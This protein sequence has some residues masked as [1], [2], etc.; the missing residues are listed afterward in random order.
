MSGQIPAPIGSIALGATLL[1]CGAGVVVPTNFARADDCLT[2]PNSPAPRGSH[3]YYQTDRATKRKCWFL[4][5]PGQ[6]TQPAAQARS[7]AAHTATATAAAPMSIGPEDSARLNEPAPQAGRPGVGGE[8]PTK[9]ARADKCLTTPN[10]PAPD[11]S[12]WYYKTDRATRRKCWYLRTL[13][14][15]T[16]PGAQATSEAASATH[17]NALKKSVTAAGVMSTSPGDHA[18]LL[19][20]QPAPMS[21]ATTNKLGQQSAHE[22][23]TGSS[24]PQAPPPQ[25]STSS[26]RSVEAAGLAPAPPAITM[27][28]VRRLVPSD[29]H[30]HSTQ[31][32][33]N[34]QADNTENT[35]RG[36]ASTNDTGT[37]TSLTANSGSTTKMV[38]II[39]L[40]LVASGLLYRAV[41]KIIAVRRRQIIV[42]HPESDWIDDQNKHKSQHRRSLNERDEL[43]DVSHPSR[44]DDRQHYFPDEPHE[45]AGDPHRSWRDN[46]Q[47]PRSPDKRDE[48]IDD[49]HRLRM[50][51]AR[52]YSAR[53]SFQ[54]DSE[55]PDSARRMGRSFPIADEV[56]DREDRL[57]QLRRDLDWLLQS[58]KGA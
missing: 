26:Q 37:A 38:L 57:E 45:P 41:M 24:V 34:A 46:R 21:S 39:A 13:A 56:S 33:A 18:T 43:I 30:A 47:E 50:L 9:M 49:L 20:P 15:P 8:V 17:S 27:L 42:E 4:L 6:A 1:V 51:G 12:H 35:A 32:M 28:K 40:V 36:S 52:D 16:Q 48:L 58:S 19:K 54:A 3:W 2:A 25:T 55:S 31:P 53:R 7:E 23:S 5:A 11:G 44:Y 22:G 10:S 14:Q 29:G